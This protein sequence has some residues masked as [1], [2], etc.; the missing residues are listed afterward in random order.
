MDPVDRIVHEPGDTLQCD[1]WFPEPR[2]PVGGGQIA[3]LPVLVSEVGLFPLYQR[4]DDP[5]P[6]RGRHPGRDVGPAHGSGCGHETVVAVSGSQR[7][8]VAGG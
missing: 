3:M 2:I 6:Q 4:A 1:L 7:S 5:D 8:V